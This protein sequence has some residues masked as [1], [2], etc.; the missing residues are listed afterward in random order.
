M[1]SSSSTITESCFPARTWQLCWFSTWNWRALLLKQVILEMYIRYVERG[2]I[3]G[4]KWEINQELSNTYMYLT[5]IWISH[6]ELIW[7][8]VYNGHDE[9]QE[10]ESVVRLVSPRLPSSVG[11]RVQCGCKLIGRL[12]CQGPDDM[13]DVY[14]GLVSVQHVALLACPS[15][16]NCTVHQLEKCK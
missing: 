8:G 6:R 15:H 3:W 9:T 5:A 10:S 4:Y 7:L 2:Y 11:W 16:Y 13:G 12:H 1:S 14:E